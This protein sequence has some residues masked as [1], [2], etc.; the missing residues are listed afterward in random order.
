[1]ARGDADFSAATLLRQ[2][3]PWQ[4]LP[5]SDEP[6]ELDAYRRFYGFRPDTEHRIGRLAIGE[7]DIAVQAFLPE[8]PVGTAVVVHGYYD[9]VGLFVH[10]IEHLLDQGLSVLSFD[11][12]G[13][14]LSSGDRVTI[15]AFDTYVGVL[16]HVVTQVM[17]EDL[18]HFPGPCHLLGQSMGGAIA[19][20]YVEQ[21][22]QA[23]FRSVTLF[24]PLI[25]PYLWKLNRIVFALAKPFLKTRPRGQGVNTDTAEFQKLRSVDPLQSQILPLQWVQAMVNWKNRF[26][27]YP[28]RPDFAPLIIQGTG[29]RVVDWQYNLSVLRRRY[30]PEVLEVPQAGHHLVNENAE[31][32]ARMF[33]WLD[34]HIAW[35]NDA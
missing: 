28:E 22:G 20:E 29:D 1:V 23:P 15:D 18:R 12:P 31:R 26:I 24:A 17:Q 11:L 30:R 3:K 10:L 9:H 19:M 35:R 13:H 2:L 21:H 8:K 14:G 4:A 7:H 33:A 25:V 27:R 5:L 34:A 16:R 32:R 6:D